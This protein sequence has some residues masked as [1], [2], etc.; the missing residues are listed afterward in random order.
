MT[1][2]DRL[3][4]GY[5]IDPEDI[6]RVGTALHTEKR[7]GAIISEIERTTV[8]NSPARQIATHYA[9]LQARKT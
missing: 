2:I 9:Q 5:A 8:P 1:P 6:A 7:G 4:M 3:R